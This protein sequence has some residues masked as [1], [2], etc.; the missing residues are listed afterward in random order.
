MM[1]KFGGD[2]LFLIDIIFSRMFFCWMD[3]DLCFGL[4]F[5]TAF[6]SDEI[7]EMMMIGGCQKTPP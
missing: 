4:I 3:L 1:V 2:P 5:L 7:F 6:A